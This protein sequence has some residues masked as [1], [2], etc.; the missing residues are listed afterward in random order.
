VTFDSKFTNQKFKVVG[1]RPPRPDG[2]DKVTGRAKY[3]ADSFAPGQLV[4]AILRSPHAHAKIKSIDTSKAEKLQGVKAVVTSADMPDLTNGD[5]G[6]F[7]T[8]ENCMARD[9]ALYDGHAVAAV[10]AIDAE[11]ARKAL[12]LIKVSYKKLPH[13]TDVDAAMK[14]NAPIVQPHVRTRGGE[15]SDKPSN[16]VAISTFGHGDVEAGFA[17]A[18]V[19]VEKSFKTEQSHQGYIEPHACLA[20]LGPDGQG[21]MWVTTQGHYTI[22]NTCCALLGRVSAF[23]IRFRRVSSDTGFET[24]SKAPDFIALIAR[25]ILPCA[26]I[27]AAGRLG[28]SC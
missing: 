10:A 23:S 26:V 4:G 24:K 18:D 17:K 7:D 2:L 14:A 19:I 27:T 22:R 21:E 15:P 25:S 12:K 11:T 8:L 28:N 16:I 13:V 5:R 3:G 20:T 6:M 1:T 9:R